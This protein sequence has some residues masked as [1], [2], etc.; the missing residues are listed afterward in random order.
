[1]FN[2]YNFPQISII[3]RF[4]TVYHFDIHFFIL[5]YFIF[6]WSLHRNAISSVSPS[7]KKINYTSMLCL[8]WYMYILIEVI[9]I[10]CRRQKP[11]NGVHEIMEAISGRICKEGFIY[12]VPGKWV[13]S[14]LYSNNNL[15][16]KKNGTVLCAFVSSTC[17]TM[18]ATVTLFQD[19]DLTIKYFL[20]QR[21]WICNIKKNNLKLIVVIIVDYA[22]H[23]LKDW[24]KICIYPT[25]LPLAGSDTRAI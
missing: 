11:V 22:G 8:S 14:C 6:K 7:V 10:I 20:S 1:M 9:A 19:P 5:F 12:K 4:T 25:L 2:L 16:V 17:I 21:A 23:F 24:W 15:S 3:V 13:V 18:S